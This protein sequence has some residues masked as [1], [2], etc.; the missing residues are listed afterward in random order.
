MLAVLTRAQLDRA[1]FP[2]GDSTKDAGARGGRRARP[3][4]RR[5]ARLAR[6]LLHRR[7]RHPRLPRAAGSA[8]RRATSSTAAPATVLGHA[9][10]GA[11][12]YT[13]GQRKGLDLRVPGAGRPAPLRAVD[14]PGDQHGDRRPARGPRRRHGDRRPGRSGTARADARS[15]A[16]CSCARTARW[17]P[18]VV[19]VDGAGWPRRAAHAR[20]AGSPPARRSW[21]TGRIRPATSCSARRPSAGWPRAVAAPDVGR[22]RC[23]T[24]PGRAGCAPP[25]IGSLPGTDI[26][27][28][29]RHRPG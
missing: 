15:S 8:R 10:T 22:T 2:L 13:I 23:L 3:G 27:E 14:H 28:A 20:P 5:Q 7:R 21:P 18:A 25:A 9:T 1:V 16:R 11:Y 6:H 29:Q 12:G 17:S 26:A 4:G 24:F 19:T